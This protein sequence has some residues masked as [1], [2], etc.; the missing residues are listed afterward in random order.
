LAAAAVALASGEV[1]GDPLAG[2]LAELVEVD[3]LSEPA[4]VTGTAALRRVPRKCRT[5]AP[6]TG[7]MNVAPPARFLLERAR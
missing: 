6:A 4:P 5:V 3:R 1:S 2:D 7:V